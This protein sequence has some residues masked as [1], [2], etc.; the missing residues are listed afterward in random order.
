MFEHGPDQSTPPAHGIVAGGFFVLSLET[1]AGGALYHSGAK[2]QA[3]HAAIAPPAAARDN[4]CMPHWTWTER[5]F[6]FSFPPAKFPEILERLRGTPARLEER[7][8]GVSDDALRRKFDGGW[9]I[10]ENA[11]H[12]CDLEPLW[13]GR[14]DDFL[15]GRDTLRPADMSNERTFAA[16]HNQRATAE[17]LGSFRALRGA[18]LARLEALDESKWTITALHPRLRTPMR[19]VDACCFVAEHDDYHLARIGHLLGAARG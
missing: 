2:L 3:A 14:L 19:V 6:D 15:A 4:P 13:T 12:L 18:H 5:T 11:G 1:G 9:T 10:I 7:L 17:V 8:R 16:G